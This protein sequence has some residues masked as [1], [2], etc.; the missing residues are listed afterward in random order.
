MLQLH[1]R[2]PQVKWAKRLYGQLIHDKRNL[3]TVC[4]DCHVGHASPKL[5]HWDEQEF[6]VALGIEPRSKLARGR[7]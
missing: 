6:C 7:K 5:V 4:A 1:H 2:F 3:M